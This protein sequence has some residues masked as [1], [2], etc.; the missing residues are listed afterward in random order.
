MSWMWQKLFQ[1]FSCSFMRMESAV[2]RI[3]FSQCLAD[4]LVFDFRDDWGSTL[5]DYYM[6]IGNVRNAHGTVGGKW[7]WI[8]N[9]TSVGVSRKSTEFSPNEDKCSCVG[10][11]FDY[12]LEESFRKIRCRIFFVKANVLIGRTFFL[13]FLFTLLCESVQSASIALSIYWCASSIPLNVEFVRYFEPLVLGS[14]ETYPKPKYLCEIYL[15]EKSPVVSNFRI[16]TLLI[17]IS[18]IFVDYLCI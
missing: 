8:R 15:R 14:F 17:N 13:F 16:S 5:S 9:V 1:N 10:N 2:W 4:V 7:I 6:Q 3:S 11:I 18:H 12:Y